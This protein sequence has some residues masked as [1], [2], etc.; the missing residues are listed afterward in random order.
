M[1]NFNKYQALFVFALLATTLIL[2]AAPAQARQHNYHDETWR[3]AERDH[4]R[5]DVRVVIRFGDQ[6][7]EVIRRYQ[8]AHYYRCPPGLAKKHNGCRPPG[9]IKHRHFVPGEILTEDMVYEPVPHELL[10][11]LRP[12]PR[13]AYYTIVDKNVLLVSEGTKHILDAVEL[14]SAVD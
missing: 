9:H 13:G 6:D 3:H 5:D 8:V 7:R 2:A 10:V 1:R 12:A 11:Q 4:D 14:F